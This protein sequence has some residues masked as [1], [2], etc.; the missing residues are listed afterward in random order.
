MFRRAIVFGLFFSLIFTLACQVSVPEVALL[1]V[2]DQEI[3]NNSISISRVDMDKP[4]WLVIHLMASEDQPNTSV[5]LINAYLVAGKYRDV[6]LPLATDLIGELTVVAMLYYDEPTDKQFTPDS[7]DPPVEVGGNQ[8]TQ[9]LTLTGAQVTPVVEVESQDVT[10]Y[11]V[12]ISR[13]VIDKPGWV[14][15]HPATSE[16]QP[17]AAIDLSRGHISIPGEYVDLQLPII[18]TLTGERTIFAMLHYDDPYDGEF[19]FDPGNNEDIPV[20]VNGEIVAQS[21][22]ARG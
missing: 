21:F 9:T 20:T 1:E 4:G 7:G 14:V 11:V 17:D 3:S 18:G 2:N 22:M 10:D 19:T 6:N 15:L 5:S 16:G 12:T 13:I 8:L